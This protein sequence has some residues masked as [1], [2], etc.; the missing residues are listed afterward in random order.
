M[1]NQQKLFTPSILA[2]KQVTG[3]ID[4][5]RHVDPLGFNA[6]AIEFATHHLADCANTVVIHR[7]AA[8]VDGFGEQFDRILGVRVDPLDHALFICVEI[9]RRHAGNEQR[10]NCDDGCKRM[11]SHT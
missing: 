3:T 8:Y 11:T 1:T 4:L 9:R 10:K 2:T 5:G 7:A 6:Q